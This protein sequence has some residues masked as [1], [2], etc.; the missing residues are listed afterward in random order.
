MSLIN[1]SILGRSQLK[2]GGAA[3]GVSSRHCLFPRL[4]S[5][6]PL[7]RP[8][9]VAGFLVKAPGLGATITKEICGR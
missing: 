7:A 2:P 5:D 1:L 8:Q 6:L 9:A 3:F 4:L